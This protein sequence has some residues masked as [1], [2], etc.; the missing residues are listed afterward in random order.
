M[1]FKSNQPLEH[2]NQVTPS[3]NLGADSIAQEVQSQVAS[4]QIGHAGLAQPGILPGA[5]SLTGALA[6]P[7]AEQTVSPLVQMIMKMPG[8]IGLASSFFEFLGSFFLPQADLLN[9][10]DIGS[11]VT[12]DN[13]ELPGMEHGE[14]DLSLL[15]D[16]APILGMGEGLAVNHLDLNSLKL[17]SSLGHS[18]GQALSREAFPGLA[19]GFNPSG[20]LNVS[21]H[22]NGSKSLFEGANHL[23]L[24]GPSLGNN[25]GNHIA[26]ND[27]L[28]SDSLLSG[29]NFNGLNSGT[30]L[31]ASPLNQGTGTVTANSLNVGSTTFSG[32]TPTGLEGLQTGDAS[33]GQLVAMDNHSGYQ[34][35]IGAMQ[36]PESSLAV[37]D[38]IGGLKAKALSLDGNQSLTDHAN[39][40]HANPHSNAGAGDTHSHGQT[41]AHTNAAEKIT[42]KQTSHGHQTKLART[43][44]LGHGK[45]LIAQNTNSF[46]SQISQPQGGEINQ[47]SS[48][49]TP[50]SAS[51]EAPPV[52]DVQEATKI[53]DA[54]NY[55]VKSG[56]T[57]WDIAKN[58]FGDGSRWTE[59]YKLNQDLLGTNPDLIL[60]GQNLQMPNGSELATTA[61]YTV[62][63]GDNLWD[64]AKD[65]L[66]DGGRWGE[67]YN[68]N[69]NII[70]DNPRL[71]H[72]GQELSLNGDPNNAVQVSQA[73]VDPNAATPATNLMSQAPN[74]VIQQG[75]TPIADANFAQP[76]PAPQD[77][78][79]YGSDSRFVE[80]NGM[81]QSRTMSNYEPM[82][83]EFRVDP[84]ALKVETPM[85]KPDSLLQPAHAAQVKGLEAAD[86]LSRASHPLNHVSTSMAS[87]ILSVLKK[88]P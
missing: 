7:G 88:R 41:K 15:P 6:V 67:I 26:P 23:R 53:T 68:N 73:P 83:S 4:Q 82:A 28:F 37:G 11:L 75:A 43:S 77:I 10:L 39:A 71:I 34:S 58:H 61:H 8:H 64:I 57:L 5:D 14:F 69:Q 81:E 78:Q 60:P 47:V 21:G 30:N 36:Q 65:K 38:Q 63:P 12:G 17:N 25:I 20:H 31:V 18:A 48:P 35:T 59:I 16:D 45:T 1:E 46:N 76:S 24:S 29:G 79:S 50:E 51:P 33:Q 49:Q 40:S 3:A 66:G 19:R 70:G 72:P 13:L 55:T 9:G 22:L 85:A 27:R 54:P 84:P 32:Q 62:Q 42:H 44:N 74:P 86:K 87:D 80:A 52:T 56:D 2:L